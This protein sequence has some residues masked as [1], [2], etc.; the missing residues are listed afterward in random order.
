MEGKE[1]RKLVRTWMSQQEAVYITHQ[2]TESK[3]P[4]ML[5]KQSLVIFKK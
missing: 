4:S 1:L 3:Y 5:L 2:C